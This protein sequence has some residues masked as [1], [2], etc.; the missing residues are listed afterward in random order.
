MNMKRFILLFSL[1]F[2]FSA[3]A[4]RKTENKSIQ[5][6]KAILINKDYNGDCYHGIAGVA[7]LK[8][9]SNNEFVKIDICAADLKYIDTLKFMDTF[10]VYKF[11][12]NS[13]K[14]SKDQ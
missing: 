3:C 12:N 5:R 6:E 9:L 11:D 1:L 4:E 8:L 7:N 13:Y 2:L 14:F 10:Y